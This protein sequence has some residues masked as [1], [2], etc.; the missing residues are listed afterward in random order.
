MSWIVCALWNFGQ[1][2]VFVCVLGQSIKSWQESEWVLP[3]GGRS[4]L[5]GQWRK[6][7]ENQ[8]YIQKQMPLC[9]SWLSFAAGFDSY[10]VL[11]FQERVVSD[12]DYF[13]QILICNTKLPNLIK[14]CTH[15]Q[16]VQFVLHTSRHNP[17]LMLWT[18][19]GKDDVTYNESQ[20]LLTS[21]LA[22]NF[23]LLKWS[24]HYLVI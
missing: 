24:Y 6:G 15:F 2:K 22:P 20:I 16:F 12:L 3:E 17:L 19:K 21:T 8:N 10:W 11:W 18:T 13:V 4:E 5:C 14:I 1:H 9:A 23:A 7:E